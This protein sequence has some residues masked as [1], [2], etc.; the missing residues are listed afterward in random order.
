MSMMRLLGLLLCIAVCVHTPVAWAQDDSAQFEVSFFGGADTTPPPTPTI[1]SVTP[2]T[3][4]QI[5][6][7]WGAVVDNRALAGYTVFRDSVPIATTTQT[8]YS[9]TGLAPTTTYSYMVRAFDG[10]FNYST[11]S[12]AVATTTLETP[13]DPPAVPPVFGTAARAVVRD[14]SITSGLST[15]SIDFTTATP[16]RVEI[17]WGQSTAYELGAS[18]GSVFTR[19]HSLLITDLT[20]DTIYY[21]EVVVTLPSGRSAVLKAGQFTTQGE[22]EII[23]PANVDQFTAVADGVDVDLS[24]RLPSTVEGAT[25]RIVRNYFWFPSF[26]TDGAIV[27]QGNGSGFT[28]KDIL[29]LRSPVYYTAFVY[30]AN[31]SVSSGALVM[32]VAP[33]PPTIGGTDAQSNA[34]TPPTLPSGT[35]VS[36]ATS[37]TDAARTAT[38]PAIVPLLEEIFLSQG[39]YEVSFAEPNIQLSAERSV[40]FSIPVEVV[41]GSFKS[42]VGT[43]VDPTDTRKEFSFL[44]RINNDQT[45]YE[46]VIAPVQVLGVS[47][48]A[49]TIYNFESLQLA[50]YQTP[51]TFVEK[52]PAPSGAL[53]AWF[54]WWPYVM[55]T[56]ALLLLLRWLL[57]MW[58]HRS[59]EDN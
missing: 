44:L 2:V 21:Y 4:T 58:L 57:L 3:H 34:G 28:D 56:G 6:V 30:D 11:N 19:S 29:G 18:V 25:V 31:G 50:T 15:T 36:E 52:I 9:D 22:V 7:V 35:F 13:P 40:V 54:D 55:A 38:P 1:T 39:D 12:A 23:A 47:T 14:F 17:R 16:N 42:I 26:P 33:F 59:R 32:V 53:S 10:A 5:D 24:W 48:A 27:Y 43:I 49:I 20:P 8:N 37:T 45:A 46:A 51:I 41:G